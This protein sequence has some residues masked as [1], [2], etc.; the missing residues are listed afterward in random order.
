MSYLTDRRLQLV[1]AQETKYISLTRMSKIKRGHIQIYFPLKMTLTW[2]SKIKY[3]CD[4]EWMCVLQ[5]KTWLKIVK[6]ILKNMLD[7]TIPAVKGGRPWRG[8]EV[9]LSQRR[10][11]AGDMVT[12]TGWARQLFLK[13]P[14]STSPPDRRSE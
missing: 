8:S 2:R 1:W 14:L 7:R 13:F 12:V 4:M 10:S 6:Y 9:M 11:G 5:K 3:K